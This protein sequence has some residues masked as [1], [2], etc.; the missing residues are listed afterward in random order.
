MDSG[1]KE[2]R[3][4][5]VRKSKSQK[6]RE[7]RFQGVKESESQDKES[8]QGVKTRSHG[9]RKSGNQRVW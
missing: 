1:I 8:R 3:S 7:S 4:Q 6:V 9:V 2:S 5:V